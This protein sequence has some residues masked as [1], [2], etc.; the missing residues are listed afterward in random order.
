MR[1]HKA[2]FAAEKEAHGATGAKDVP[3]WHGPSTVTQY[4]SN[5]ARKGSGMVS[6]WLTGAYTTIRDAGSTLHGRENAPIP[7]FAAQN[8]SITGAGQH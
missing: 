3:A 4:F 7:M 2:V 5:R 8:I 6:T 1:Y